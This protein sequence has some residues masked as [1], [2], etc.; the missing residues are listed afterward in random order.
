MGIGPAAAIPVAVKDAGLELD[1]ID[2]F[3]INEVFDH[4]CYIFLFSCMNIYTHFNNLLL[5]RHLL[6]SSYIAV[7]SWG[8]IQKKSMLME[9]QWQLGI[10][11]VQQVY[12]ATFISHSKCNNT[13]A[14]TKTFSYSHLYIK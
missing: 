5:L 11:W 14:I 9:V 4:V 8:L 10:L 7:T 12:T 13:T 6:P 1:D 2:L 3:E